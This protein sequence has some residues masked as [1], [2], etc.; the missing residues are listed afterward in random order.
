MDGTFKSC[1]SLFQQIY[2]IHGFYRG[3]YL[4]LAFILMSK[5][6]AAAYGMILRKIRL[7]ALT[8]DAQGLN[9]D[10]IITDFEHAIFSAVEQEFPATRHY[11]C[12]FHYCQALFRFIKNNGLLNQFRDSEDFRKNFKLKLMLPFLP[13]E[14]IQYASNKINQQFD[15]PNLFIEYFDNF[16]LTKSS[17]ISVYDR[18][19]FRTNNASEGY[20]SGFNRNVG[21]SRTNLWAFIIKLREEE[22]FSAIRKQKLDLGYPPKSQKAKFRRRDEDILNWKRNFDAQNIDDVDFIVE[23]SILSRLLDRNYDFF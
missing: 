22:A 7:N 12:F 6:N 15:C 18:I 11:G 19:L 14:R 4:P 13:S 2:I 20:N 17:I 9:P 10:M 1:P 5:R 3:E 8:L 16:W 23:L 21:Y